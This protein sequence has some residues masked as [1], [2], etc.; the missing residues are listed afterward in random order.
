MQV[1]LTQDIREAGSLKVSPGRVGQTRKQL[2]PNGTYVDVDV[3]DA[4]EPQPW[5]KGAVIDM[6]EATARKY[7]AAGKAVPA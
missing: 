7:I 2:Q 1:K 4:H 3:R 5:V 6:S